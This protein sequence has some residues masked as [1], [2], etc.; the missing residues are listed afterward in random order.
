MRALLD[1]SVLVALLDSDHAL[2]SAA[3]EHSTP[4]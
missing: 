3:L 1:V 4:E 2:H